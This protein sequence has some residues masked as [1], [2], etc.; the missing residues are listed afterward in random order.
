MAGGRSARVCQRMTSATTPGTTLPMRLAF[1]SIGNSKPEH[2]TWTQNR[3]SPARSERPPK[4]GVRVIDDGAGWQGTQVN[5]GWSQK[6]CWKAPGLQATDCW[7]VK[8]ADYTET[9][10]SSGSIVFTR[11]CIAPSVPE[12]ALGQLPQAPW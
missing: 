12:V 1:H 10:V 11:F 2:E 8:E 5:R 4:P 6:W 9:T 3:L 7:P